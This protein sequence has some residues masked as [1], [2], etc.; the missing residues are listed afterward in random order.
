MK[1]KV[2][3]FRGAP[4]SGKG[5]I[6]PEFAKLLPQPVA[7]IEQDKFRWGFHLVGRS[8]GDIEPKEHRFAYE[9]TVSLYERYLE[10]KT[11]T[12]VIEGLFTWDDVHSNE[13][14]AKQLLNIANQHGFEATSIVLT[15]DKEELV[16]RNSKRP[17][18]VPNEEFE[19]LYNGVYQK[20]DTSEIVID[21]TG[22]SVTETLAKLKSLFASKKLNESN[23]G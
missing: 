13:G 16:K 1:S 23:R 21:T 11:Y 6:A 20:I 12:I 8:I 5:T 7:L 17:Y 2:Y 18:S 15:A 4:A 3:I 9:N 22:E 14:N 19:A 10:D